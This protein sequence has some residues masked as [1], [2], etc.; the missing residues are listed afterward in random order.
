[1]LDETVT[2]IVDAALK[3]PELVIHSSD[4]PAAALAVR[5]VLAGC[6]DLYDRGGPVRLARQRNG[7]L[8]RAEPLSKNQV[9]VLTHQ[10]CQ[11]VK[12]GSK[13]NSCR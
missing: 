3:K 4:L 12:K 10:R 9:V 6:E 1:M 8:P 7:K 13:G 5:E 11:P 2:K